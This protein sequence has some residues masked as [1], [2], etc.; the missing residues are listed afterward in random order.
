MM[1]TSED[2]ALVYQINSKEVERM[3]EKKKAAALF[4]AAVMAF[5]VFCSGG[6]VFADD[7]EDEDVSKQIE[8]VFDDPE[9]EE[10]VDE[11]ADGVK[12]FLDGERLTFEVEPI[13]D[14]VTNR[15]LVPLRAIFEAMGAV[16]TWDDETKTATAVKEETVVVLKI[17]GDKAIVNDEVV[18]LDQ[19]AIIVNDRTLA[20]LRFVA[21]AFDGDVKWDSD[22]R[23]AYIITTEEDE[24]VDEDVTEEDGDEEP[25][26]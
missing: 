6:F 9:E 22:T 21:E 5:S 10:A 11:S 8:E 12:V 4:L 18:D 16:V 13:I 15:T 19:P 2:D 17:G 7:P 24:P 26:E 23:T 3:K 25:E 20:P 14:P 1:W